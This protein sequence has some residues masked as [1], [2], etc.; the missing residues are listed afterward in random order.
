MPKGTIIKTDTGKIK[1]LE[2]CYNLIINTKTGLVAGCDT[3]EFQGKTWVIDMDTE[4]ATDEDF[5][6]KI[7]AYS[8]LD[9]N[10]RHGNWTLKEERSIKY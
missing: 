9:R 4:T 2:A 1:I 10:I 7:I 5:D 8:K 6:T 3:L